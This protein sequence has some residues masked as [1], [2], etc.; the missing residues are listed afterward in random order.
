[1]WIDQTHGAQ[2]YTAA[3]HTLTSSCAELC[4][5]LQ[6]GHILLTVVMMVTSDIMQVAFPTIVQYLN[7]PFQ[8]LGYVPFLHMYCLPFKSSLSDAKSFVSYT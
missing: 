1:M 4:A 3:R 8:S 2:Q 7:D 5:Y 6:F